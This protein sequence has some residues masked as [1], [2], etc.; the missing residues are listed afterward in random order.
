MRFLKTAYLML[1][2]KNNKLYT[3]PFFKK[4][5]KNKVYQQKNLTKPPT[6]FVAYCNTGIA[7]QGI[8]PVAEKS[9]VRALGFNYFGKINLLWGLFRQRRDRQ[10]IPLNVM[11][12]AALLV[13]LVCL[14][15]NQSTH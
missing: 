4:L 3:N 14:W 5:I 15:V 12:C 2:K 9:Q 6:Q 10:S 11:L 1:G 13:I 8:P 7:E